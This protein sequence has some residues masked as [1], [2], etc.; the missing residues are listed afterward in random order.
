MKIFR[1]FTIL[2]IISISKIAK[3][4]PLKGRINVNITAIPKCFRP[5]DGI[6]HFITQNVTVS[7]LNSTSGELIFPTTS[8]CDRKSTFIGNCPDVI[9]KNDHAF[10]VVYNYSNN[11]KVF[12]K[13]FPEDCKYQ[14][15]ET[16]LVF[17]C[18]FGE[19]DPN[20]P[21]PMTKNELISRILDRLRPSLALG[22]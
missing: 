20:N 19:L 14:Y 4:Y 9:M 7:L 1:I 6:L 21:K 17:D 5:F 12:V 3:T 18:I 8:K 2:K 11:I 13:K 22:G 10:Y 16:S 15:D